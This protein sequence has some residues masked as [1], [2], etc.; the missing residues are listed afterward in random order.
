MGAESSHID[1]ICR[2]SG[3]PIATVSGLLTMMELKGL[4]M[5]TGAMNYVLA[6]EAREHCRV[7]ID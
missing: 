6:K 4:V 5:Q 2:S 1:Q 3:F 7:D